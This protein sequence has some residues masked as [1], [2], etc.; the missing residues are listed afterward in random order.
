MAESGN[1]AAGLRGHTLVAITRYSSGDS[2]EAIFGI[3]KR[4]HLRY[5]LLPWSSRSRT[6]YGLRLGNDR[7]PLNEREKK[8]NHNA[9]TPLSEL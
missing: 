3:G 2:Q 8:E 9:R 6:K 5:T 4:G 7:V 1:T